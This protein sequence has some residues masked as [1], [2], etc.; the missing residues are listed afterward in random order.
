M[1]KA[2]R[3]LV[4][5]HFGSGK[6]EVAVFFALSLCAEQKRPMLL[7]LDFITPYYRSR[8]VADQLA[9]AGVEVVRPAGDLW[10]SDLPVVAARAVQAMTAYDGPVVAD[11]GG[12]EGARVLGSMRLGPGTYEALMVVNPYRPDTGSPE[13]VARYAR[14]LEEIGR[15]R[16][17][18]LVNN[19]N[20]GPLTRPEHVLEGLKQVEEAARLLDLPVCCT[21]VRADLV[22]ALPGLKL[23]P[24]RL[25][26]RP[27]WEAEPFALA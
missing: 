4:V 15:I 7:D 20:L 6:T 5:G 10:R 16:L 22:D 26:M 24:L 8:D 9:A 13:Q 23:L 3:T 21:A 27:P 11:I 19:A 2:A 14:W 25:C 17:T 18:G 12:G 1:E